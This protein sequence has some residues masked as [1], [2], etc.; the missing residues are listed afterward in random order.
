[1]YKNHRPFTSSI[2]NDTGND[3]LT[4]LYVHQFAD[5][6]EHMN[7]INI[8]HGLNP[9]QDPAS[10]NLA[11][12]THYGQTKTGIYIKCCLIYLNQLKIVRQ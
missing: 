6:P 4:N 3:H 5:S 7:T 12:Q 8:V 1:M 11:Q 10:L 9:V 2:L